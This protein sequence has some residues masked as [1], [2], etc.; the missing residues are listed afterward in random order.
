MG[1]LTE[2]K[3]NDLLNEAVEEVSNYV[4]IATKIHDMKDSIIKSKSDMERP[5]VII[6]LAGLI[7]AEYHFIRLY[8]SNSEEND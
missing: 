8:G 4:A 2:I 7:Q 6:D 1:L 3:E 5:R